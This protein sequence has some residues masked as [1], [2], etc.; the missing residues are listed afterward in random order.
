MVGSFLVDRMGRRP[1]LISSYLGTGI[2][3][4]IVGL[5]LFLLNVIHVDSL[6]NYSFVPVA[7]IIASSVISTFGF[8]ALSSVIPAE[9]FPLNVKAVAMTSL[10]IFGGV[11]GF[12]V[13]KGYQ[14]VKDVL[15]LHGVFWIFASIAFFGAVFSYFV[16]PETGGKSL[17]DIQKELQ[18][19]AYEDAEEKFKE[20][21]LSDVSI[22][23]GN[24]EYI[25]DEN[26]GTELE[27]L[28]KKNEQL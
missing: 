21:P 18:G 26:E 24:K 11:L 7:A 19:D 17:N 27:D 12:V 4:V 28:T 22:I 14:N 8:V 15:D 13:G 10:N 2:S 6:R 16:I 3:L 9:I 23:N 5:H 20:I 1:L 25:N